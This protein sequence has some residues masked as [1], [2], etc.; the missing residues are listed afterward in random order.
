MVLANM[1]VFGW[2]SVMRS[3]LRL[4]RKSQ[5]TI[6]EVEDGA[7]AIILEEL[8][9]AFVYSNARERRYY[10]NIKHLDSE[11]LATI[12][13]IVTHLEVG[14]RKTKDWERAILRGY[15]AFRH[16][17][18]NREALLHLDLRTRDLILLK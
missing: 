15:A 4:K 16:L 17:L 11:M 13:R 3:F 8:V 14:T 9:V 1:A 6:D 10:E 5:Q 2:S 18:Q 12:K 7:R